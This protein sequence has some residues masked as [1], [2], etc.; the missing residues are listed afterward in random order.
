MYISHVILSDAATRVDAPTFNPGYFERGR[1]LGR[2][3]QA[4]SNQAAVSSD[5]Y[6]SSVDAMNQHRTTMELDLN[7]HSRS[8]PHSSVE[9]YQDATEEEFL[10]STFKSSD[11]TLAE[12]DVSSL[13]VSSVS[14]GTTLADNAFQEG[15]AQLD[16]NIAKLQASLKSSRF[17][18]ST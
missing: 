12:Q 5:V 15:L 14:L 6:A 4:P 2:D 1:N 17:N 16:A 3:Y 7:E 10:H 8:I 18:S 9:K 13:S 11:S